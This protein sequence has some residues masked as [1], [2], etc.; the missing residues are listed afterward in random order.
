MHCWHILMI[1]IIFKKS[2]TVLLKSPRVQI[3]ELWFS[4]SLFLILFSFPLYIKMGLAPP[5]PNH[6]ISS[7]HWAYCFFSLCKRIKVSCIQIKNIYKKKKNSFVWWI[8]KLGL[9]FFVLSPPPLPRCRCDIQSSGRHLRSL[10]T[11][12][13]TGRSS[14]GTKTQRFPIIH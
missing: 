8:R 5:T 9:D 11:W 14:Q 3:E 12:N 7:H 1:K 10:W 4:L 2:G 13:E 6:F